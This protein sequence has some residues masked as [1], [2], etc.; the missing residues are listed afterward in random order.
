MI[1]V[2]DIGLCKALTLDGNDEVGRLCQ[3]GDSWFLSSNIIDLHENGNVKNSVNTL[4]QIMPDTVCAYTYM[5]DKFGT[6][7]FEFDVLSSPY[8]TDLLIYVYY[9]SVR[10]MYLYHTNKSIEEESNMG[11]LNINEL[12]IVGNITRNDKLCELFNDKGDC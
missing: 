8:N 12:V 3:I 11:P 1:K 7:I 4:V 9:D 6:M 2:N 10:G 5:N